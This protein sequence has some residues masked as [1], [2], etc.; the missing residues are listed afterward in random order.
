MRVWE[1][2]WPCD[3]CAET[4]ARTIE[5]GEPPDAESCTAQICE[6]CVRKAIA[7]LDEKSAHRTGCCCITCRNKVM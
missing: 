3:E 6:S 5:L 2:Q 4:V 7:L 1:V